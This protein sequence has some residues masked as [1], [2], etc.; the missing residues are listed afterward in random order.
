MMAPAAVPLLPLLVM[1]AGM[2]ALPGRI[3]ETTRA[4]SISRTAGAHP[5]S[6]LGQE[7]VHGR[8]SVALEVRRLQT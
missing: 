5:G 3:R 6:T 4:L 2:W 7:V 8:Q 1:H